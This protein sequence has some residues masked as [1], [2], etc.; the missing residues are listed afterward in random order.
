MARFVCESEGTEPQRDEPVPSYTHSCCIE[1]AIELV[2]RP[3]LVLV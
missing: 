2:F 1:S 3:P